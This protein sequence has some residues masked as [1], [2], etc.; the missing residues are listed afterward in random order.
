VRGDERTPPL[1]PDRGTWEGFR[2]WV[3]HA[4]DP[5]ENARRK[6]LGDKACQVAEDVHDGRLTMPDAVVVLRALCPDFDDL[7]YRDALGYGLHET[8]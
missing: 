4:S 5:L 8:K 1:A 2:H 7:A 3:A 6:L